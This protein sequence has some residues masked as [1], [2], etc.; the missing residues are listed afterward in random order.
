[1]I[2]DPYKKGIH[3]LTL[4]VVHGLQVPI[5]KQIASVVLSVANISGDVERIF[6]IGGK[7]RSPDRS[8]LSGD[9][10]SMLASLYYWLKEE[11]FHVYRKDSARKAKDKRLY[12]II[13]LIIQ[14]AVDDEDGTIGEN[15]VY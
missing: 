11:Y 1:M 13:T 8:C 10:V 6:S 12:Q 9:S 15:E 3:P 4:Y 7:I 14:A 5:L 2:Q